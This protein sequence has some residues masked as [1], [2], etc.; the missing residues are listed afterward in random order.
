MTQKITTCLW[1]DTQAEEAADFYV[2]V[3]DNSRILN[4]AR[5]GDAGPG[6]PGQAMTVEFEIE[7]WKFVALNGGPAFTFTEAI[8]FVIDCSSQDE[9]DR[10]WGALTTGGSESQCGWLKDKFGVSWQVVPSV[11]GSLL[12]GPDPAGAQRAMEAML[13]MRKLEIRELEAAY[14]GS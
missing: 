14:K 2:S 11:L 6:T 8:S 13:G 5:Y 10:Y 7:R 3:F 12:G 9:V 1:F 4:T